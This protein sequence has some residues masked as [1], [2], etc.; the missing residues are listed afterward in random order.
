ML[1]RLAELREASGADVQAVSDDPQKPSDEI[2]DQKQAAGAADD[3]KEEPPDDEWCELIDEMKDLYKEI[4]EDEGA[5]MQAC[6]EVRH[7]V[8]NMEEIVQLERD[9][10]LPTKLSQLA[11]RFESQELVCQRM[12]RRAKEMLTALRAEDQDY[13][14][15]DHAHV[16]LRAVRNSI[17]RARA[18]EFKDLIQG[19]FTARNRNKQEMMKRASR[20]L[21]FAYPD[22]LDEELNDIMEYPELAMV[23]IARRLEQGSEVTLDG[24]LGEMEGKKADA[25]KLEQG[26]KELKLMFLQFSELIDTQ[27]AG[28]SGIEANIKTVLEE[29]TEAIGILQDAEMEKR[30]YERKKLKFIIA[31]FFFVVYVLLRYVGP[32]FLGPKKFGGSLCYLGIGC[33]AHPKAPAASYYGSGQ[34]DWPI[35]R[36]CWSWFGYGA[37]APPRAPASL[38]ESSGQH[39]DHGQLQSQEADAGHIQEGRKPMGFVAPRAPVY[40]HPVIRSV[41]F[42]ARGNFL[43][44][45]SGLRKTQISSQEENSR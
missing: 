1:G 19:F 21:R 7:C 30:A 24:I 39:L 44:R 26:A 25:Q 6:T 37:S 31:A 38:L 27:D 8:E 2:L 40:E 32:F 20:Q 12:I 18:L 35:S 9:A 4:L 43:K 45:H 34:S 5:T 14:E 15:D 36:W 3:Q 28:L 33:G 42:M 11:N 10:L 41:A 29:T 16:A 22:A 23:A 13:D 17:A